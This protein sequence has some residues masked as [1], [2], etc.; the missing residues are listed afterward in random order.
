MSARD[1][2]ASAL[3][4]PA[5]PLPS[6]VD[7]EKGVLSCM[8]QAPDYAGPLCA[9]LL[10]A[11]DFSVEAHAL[12]FD[13]LSILIGRGTPVDPPTVTQI[14]YDRDLIKK[15]GGP[16][17]ISEIYTASPNPAHVKH[18]ADQV[19][20]KSRRRTFV[21]ACWDAAQKVMEECPEEA[22]FRGAIEELEGQLL[23]V[24]KT[25]ATSRKGLRDGRDL[26]LDVVG[27]MKTRYANR[28]KVLGLALGFHD[29]DRTIN[30]LQREDFVVVCARPA[31]GKTALAGSIADNIAVNAVNE[32]NVPVLMITLEMSDQQIMERSILGRARMMFSKGRNGMFTDAEGSVWRT[33]EEVIKAHRGNDTDALR[34]AI[35]NTA[36]DALEKYWAY[37][38]EKKG[39]EITN[40]K[41]KAAG[42]EID[43]LAR[44]LAVNCSGLLTFYNAYGPPTAEIR[45][46]IRRWVKKIGWNP[47]GAD[48]VPPL[49]IIDYIQLVK[50]SQKKN[51]G[52]LRL[53]LIE[54]CDVLKGCAK[55]L[56]I[57]IMPLAQIGR[58]AEGN[59]G[60]RPMM[61]DIQE[62]GAVEQYADLIM[63]LHRDSYY[64]KWEELNEAAQG[65]WEK[66]AKERNAGRPREILR[67]DAWTGQSFYEAQASVDILK[68][69]NAAT[70]RVEILFHGPQMRFTTK[71]PSLFSN[72]AENRQQSSKS[73]D[74]LE[75]L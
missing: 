4:D 56:S 72:S 54:V 23:A 18:Y 44:A 11:E 68:G 34:R 17:T 40:A 26:T 19:A 10:K 42:E 36:I 31:M 1:S 20:Q 55:E 38:Q 46:V 6:A 65:H 22:D 67:E 9:D 52:D 28:G 39:F 15:I 48:L 25:A 8:M 71:T 47:E 69:R 64:Q 21:R 41:L 16:A 12:I 53:T 58:S 74:E 24:Q 2:S 30:G 61:K 29:L 51:H 5:T 50:S 7:M 49:V 45:G 63:A 43:N 57:C 27:A 75:G 33:A 13:V 60:N 32:H 14:F 3:Y 59:K 73:A 35:F 66:E 37:K 62:S 70:G